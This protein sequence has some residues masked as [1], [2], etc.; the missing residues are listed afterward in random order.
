M[1]ERINRKHAYQLFP[2]LPAALHGLQK[3]VAASGLSPT[4]LH[5][6]SIRSSQI[7]GCAFCLEMHHQAARKDGESQERLDMISAW[8][9]S[10]VFNDQEKSALTL[11]EVLTNLPGAEVSD[12]LYEELTRHF[13]TTEM[14]ALVS[15]IIVTNG[16]NRIVA[17]ARFSPNATRHS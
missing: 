16:W 6:L 10:G 8:R 7:N 3:D 4:L 2:G 1:A 5:L 9:E 13:S 12:T 11:C 14:I 15:A 17:T